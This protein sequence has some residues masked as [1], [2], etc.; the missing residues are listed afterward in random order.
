MIE[1]LSPDEVRRYYNM[2]LPKLHQSG[3]ELRAPCP[4]HK[5]Q[6]DSLAVNGVTGTWYCH[7]ECARGGSIFDFEAAISGLDH[8]QARAEVFQIVGRPSSNGVS[9]RI[10]ATYDYTDEAGVL[11][12]QTVRY[13]PKNF[14][15]RRPDG[16]GDWVWNLKDTRLVL[17]R[18]AAVLAAPVV[19][20][21]EGERDADA[22]TELGVTATTSPLGALKWKSKYSEFLRGKQVIVIPDA[23]EKGRKHAASVTQSLTG[24]AASVKLV[25]LPGAKDAAEWIGKGGR[26]EALVELVE[27]ARQ[28]D[29][30]GHSAP[31]VSDVDSSDT[32]TDEKKP[33]RGFVHSAGAIFWIDQEADVRI[34]VCSELG[35]EA[36]TSDIDGEFWGRLLVWPDGHGRQHRIAVPMQLFAGEGVTLREIL[37]NGGLEIG[38]GR[39]SRELLSQYIQSA[40]PEHSCTCVPCIGWCGRVFVFPNS[41]MPETNT[42]LFQARERMEHAWRRAGTLSDWIRRIGQ[43]CANN[44]RLV[45]AI[46]MGFAA[47]LLGPLRIEGGGVHFTGDTSTGKTTAQAVAGS[48]CGG[49]QRGFCRSWRTTANAIESIAELHNDALLA[50]DELSEMPDPAQ[51][52]EAVYMLANG[53]GKARATASAA[54]RPIRTWRLLFLSSGEITLSEHAQA[55]RVRTRGGGEIRMLNLPADAGAGFGVFEDLHGAAS[56]REFADELKAAAGEVYGTPLRAFLERWVANWD[57]N[58]ATVKEAMAEFLV[59]ALA[60]GAAPEVGRAM[61]RIALIA[62]AGEL[63]TIWGITG[64]PEGEAKRAALCIARDWIDARGG[65]GQT[66]VEAGIHELRL[67]IATKAH[68]FQALERQ[69]DSHGNPIVERI[70]E[71]AGFWQEDEDGERVY[72]IFPGVVR[73]I[74]R[75]RNSRA[76]LKELLTRRLLEAP[77]APRH[78]SKRVRVP[79]EGLPRFYAVKAAILE[80]G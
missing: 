31:E 50:L 30:D 22:L 70:V 23:D 20:V 54:L 47:P 25:E 58:C 32:P 72:L 3:N 43:K 55:A 49:G 10:V 65:I 73:E 45:F 68:H 1:N 66:D 29:I 74:C 77:D 6:R 11:L 8:K 28:S 2:R 37:L 7:S 67:F 80:G 46:S 27:Q 9:K 64:W 44:L 26:L 36:R 15:Q 35:V 24:V 17:Y 48:V 71:R 19:F 21:V 69:Y 38:A 61:R 62:T 51:I 5:G 40:Y 56:A 78:L 14:K 42:V 52:N 18:L 60:A 53:Q 12:Y 33:R 39:R 16:K 75:G 41:T 13:E 57:T 76:V 63:A 59:E 79:N 34:F 4:I